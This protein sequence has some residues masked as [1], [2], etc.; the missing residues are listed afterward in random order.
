MAQTNKTNS[1]IPIAAIARTITAHTTRS[2]ES[3]L[4]ADA[5]EGW[6]RL[7]LMREGTA[8]KVLND[9]PKTQVA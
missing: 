7:I 6:T 1:P 2:T 8:K 3:A 9:L 4:R 5:G